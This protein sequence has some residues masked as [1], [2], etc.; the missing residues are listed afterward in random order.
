MRFLRMA[1]F[2]VTGLIVCLMVACGGDD[3]TPPSATSTPPPTYTSVPPTPKLNMPTVTPLPPTDTP[4][5][6][7]P[8]PTPRVPTVEIGGTAMNV[9]GGPGVNYVVVGTA[10][11]GQRYVVTGKN[12][13]GDWWQINFRGEYAW[14]FAQLVTATDAES[15]RMVRKIPTPPP[16]ATPVPPTP[17]RVVPTAT[18]IPAT[19]TS[20]A[21]T[22]VPPT[23]VPAQA[24][25]PEQDAQYYKNRCGVG[26]RGWVTISLARKCGFSMP[27]CRSTNPGLYAAMHDKNGDGCVGE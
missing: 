10:Q 21:P 12:P 26:K 6:V 24:S 7:P 27:V 20:V 5:S 13:Q 4:T 14:V 18:S 25:E 1:K 2:V 11:P 3:G 8:T 22:P 23:P 19:A 17:T 15:V 9:R 16:T